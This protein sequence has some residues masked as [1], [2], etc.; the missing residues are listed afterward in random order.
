[1]AAISNFYS[2]VPPSPNPYEYVH[3]DRDEL[4][5]GDWKNSLMRWFIPYYAS[6][7]DKKVSEFFINFFTNSFNED[8]ER[9][10]EKFKSIIISAE[11]HIARGRGWFSASVTKDIAR[12]EVY[13]L[14]ARTRINTFESGQSRESLIERYRVDNRELFNRWKKTG[15]AEEAFWTSPDLVD[16]LFKAHLHRNITYPYYRHTVDMHPCL[17][18][19]NG[20]LTA[21]SEPHLLVNGNSTP[22]SELRNKFK[23]DKELRPYTLEN[24]RKTYWMYLEDG[25]TKWD[26]HN[27]EHP[28]RLR[29][30]PNAPLRNRVEIITTRA[31]RETWGISDNLLKGFRHSFFRIIPGQGFSVRHPETGL[32]SGDVYSFGWAPRK[33]DF[34]SWSP[35]STMRGTWYSPDSWE[36]A[37]E[38]LYTTPIDVSDEQVLKLLEIIKKKSQEDAPFHIINAN[39]CGATVDIFNEVGILNVCPRDHMGYM[40]FQFLLPKYLRRPMI[41]AASFVN[42]FV[43]S[44]ISN[45]ISTVGKFIY[46]MIWA[47]IFSV[48]GAWRT[49]IVYEDERGQE[50][51]VKARNRVKALFSNVFD[52]FNP[53]KMDVDLTKNLYKWQKRRP[54][55]YFEKHD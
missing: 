25:L 17:S 45:G 30:L 27:F 10:K 16:F 29:R 22:W 44:C 31:H 7:Q 32:A 26:R 9:D 5:V 18:R 28:H 12:L 35:L 39:C 38:D 3:V 8:L 11:Q 21:I 43:P 50:I 13:T 33:R 51:V 54:E 53:S 4:V 49:H 46:S 48:L 41:Q 36:F 34:S 42:K 37:K 23:I 47:P 15:F 6:N 24:G 1:M 14:A 55:T 2:R 52:M 20:Q 19:R 40:W